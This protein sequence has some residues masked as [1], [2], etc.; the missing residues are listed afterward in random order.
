MSI[1]VKPYEISVWD[2]VWNGEKFVEKC[3]VI[4]GTNEMQSQ[5]KAIEPILTRNVN[6][7]KKFSFKMYKRYIDSNTGEEV[8]NPFMNYLISERKVK[9]HY[10]NKW[11][12]FIIKNINETS[13]SYLYSFDLEDALVVELSKNGFNVILDQQLNNNMN[14]ANELAKTVLADTDWVL[15]ENPE[16]FVQTIEDNLVYLTID[17]SKF[18][19]KIYHLIDQKRDNLTDG[20][21]AELAK[22]GNTGEIKVLGFYSS[23]RNKPYRFQFIYLNN[24]E[25]SNVQINSNRIILNQDCQYYFDVPN[26]D[27]YKGP[28]I[29]YGFYLPE[30]V[31]LLL[32]GG[33]SV[34]D[35][36]DTT[37]SYWYRGARYGFAQKAVYRS[38]LN[39]YVNIYDKEGTEY[40]GFLDTQYNSPN[41]LTNVVTNT[42]FK[43]TSGWTGA[44]IIDGGKKAQVENVFGNYNN[45]SFTDAMDLLKEGDFDIENLDNNTNKAYM[46]LTFDEDNQIVINSGPYDNRTLIGNLNEKEEWAICCKYCGPK[47]KDADGND[48]TGKLSFKIAEWYYSSIEQK[49]SEREYTNDQNQKYKKIEFSDPE[50]RN[51]YQIFT[52]QT[53]TYS[54]KE[55]KKKN[56]LRI[57]ITADTL[58][59]YYI[60]SLELF[61]VVY[62][63]KDKTK[64][65]IP[66]EQIDESM[67]NQLVEKKYKYFLPSALEGISD[68][69]ELTNVE[70]Y[71]APQNGTYVPVFNEGA[72]KIRSVDA[73]ESNYFNILQSIA[74]TFECWLT[75]EVTR[76]NYGAINEKKVAFKNYAGDNNY[77]AFRYGVNLKDIQRT[78][79]SKSIVTKLLV[80]QNAN[81]HAK[82]GFC[83]IQ[84]AASNPTGENYLYDFQ[85]YHNNGLLDAKTYLESIYANCG[86]ITKADEINTESL[87]GY[88]PK[89]RALNDELLKLNEQLINNSS[90]L[91]KINADYEVAKAAYDAAESGIEETENG[92]EAATGLNIRNFGKIVAFQLTN[93]Y[94][95]TE[96]SANS[97][98]K[99]S[100]FD[101][102][103]IYENSDKKVIRIDAATQNYEHCL[104][105]KSRVLNLVKGK[106]Y[107]IRIKAR[108]IGGSNKN[109]AMCDLW[110]DSLPESYFTVSKVEEDW[111]TWGGTNKQYWNFTT[112]SNT[113]VDEC[114]VRIFTNGG[115]LVN[116]QNQY[117]N[118]SFE[119]T[120]IQLI[121]DW[122]TGYDFG[123]VYSEDDFWGGLEYDKKIIDTISVQQE[124]TEKNKIK[125]TVTGYSSNGPV[126]FTAYPKIWV[127]S[128]QASQLVLNS[129]PLSVELT[130]GE[131]GKAKATGSITQTFTA[132]NTER[133]DI[134]RLIKDMTLYTIERNKK[135]AEYTRLEDEKSK[136]ESA[137]TELESN[138][139]NL[140]D[141]KAALNKLFYKN[142]YRFI[143]EGTWIDEQYVDDEKYYIDAQSVLYNS[144]YPQVA[145]AINVLSLSQLPGYELF[146][147]ELGDKT[148]VEDEQFFGT[149]LKEEII[150]AEMSNHL[151]SPSQDSIK[152]QNFKNQFQDLFQKITATVQQAQY[153]TGSYEK[154]VALAEADQEKK[155]QFLTDALTGVASAFQV[156]GQQSVVQDASGITIVDEDAPCNALKM[157]GGA[158]MLSK[159]DANGQQ[160][161]TTGLTADGISASLLTAG[162]INVGNIAIYN[163]DEPVFKWDAFGL[164]AYDAN[165]YQGVIGDVNTNK[166]VRFDKFGIYGMNN[167][168]GASWKPESEYD[169]HQNATFALTW[170]GLKVTGDSGIVARIGK[171]TDGIINITN[172]G[173]PIFTISNTGDAV[174]SGELS[175]ATGTFSGN[176][177]A[178]TR[179][180]YKWIFNTT[181]GLE[182]Y[183]KN[184]PYFKLT[185]TGA[186]LQGEVVASQGSIAGWS[187]QQQ[188]IG[189]GPNDESIYGKFFYNKIND[190]SKDL[191]NGFSSTA[192]GDGVIF[193]GAESLEKYS[194]AKLIVSQEGEVSGQSFEVPASKNNSTEKYYFS[195]GGLSAP[196]SYV[197]LYSDKAVLSPELIKYKNSVVKKQ[198]IDSYSTPTHYVAGHIRIHRIHGS[199]YPTSM[200][201][202]IIPTFTAKPDWYTADHFKDYWYSNPSGPGLNQFIYIKIHQIL[203]DKYTT[204]ATTPYGMVIS[205]GASWNNSTKLWEYTI[206]KTKANITYFDSSTISLNNSNYKNEDV[207]ISFSYTFTGE[208]QVS[209]YVKHTDVDITGIQLQGSLIP[210]KELATKNRCLG[211]GQYT[212][213]GTTT[214]DEK[215]YWWWDGYI[216]YVYSYALR[217]ESAVYDSSG[218]ITSDRLRK[219][220]IQLLSDIEKYSVLFDNLKP[221]VYKYNNGS[222]D[223]LHTGFIAQEV[224]EAMEIAEID[225]QD[226]AALTIE[227]YDKPEEEQI[228]RLRYEEFIALNTDQIQK[229][230]PRMSLAEQKLLDY[231]ARIAYLEQEVAAL[232]Q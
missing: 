212:L 183:Y 211:M 135:H 137:K 98:C 77:A 131:E 111:V 17:L 4:I 84:R 68:I 143:Q 220:S 122:Y 160:K 207:T 89:L 67:T 148:Y 206:D 15:P 76:D 45:N 165:W 113:D 168:D 35:N 216:R 167:V 57:G 196:L 62:T 72:E 184:T 222:S 117:V 112:P 147:F 142:Y 85:Y 108:L 109:N 187:L 166:F 46:K 115:V 56:D 151:D 44:S 202:Q 87:D 95:D 116:G 149:K 81:E 180:G 136:L 39:R 49:Y 154:A 182:A 88:M 41:L 215:D 158:I 105:G 190:G 121:E 170:D 186:F 130:G 1:L 48:A 29:N 82:N 129:F 100:N 23:C 119:I 123:A 209:S 14:G 63:D 21:I 47:Y 58:G 174:F 204:F 134:K 5:N 104:F 52:V 175:A 140:K 79:E 64:F 133:S 3:L 33:L 201:V 90:D 103:K 61:R 144:C 20:V 83:T 26:E 126:K 219:N 197:K 65:I 50:N 96:T 75:L 114:Y 55:F 101:S 223:R 124:G 203:W 150:I 153:S 7:V 177:S 159:Q 157:I 43:S 38:E 189:T 86:D 2:D 30:G 71:D 164:T 231:E 232:K 13:T 199:D 193:I 97:L 36:A 94:I 9:L 217:A 16:K 8:E 210:N 19:N 53:N 171:S 59:D 69:E 145:Y 156:A 18:E 172:N 179:T 176:L 107:A 92:F 120:E 224:K 91:T 132:V 208:T 161:W 22:F 205:G 80:K 141:K 42:D 173:T 106:N 118:N 70:T 74:E 155:S 181:S 51:E 163:E 128:E 127:G 66:N 198:Q 54:Q 152:V 229:L 218:Q 37:I 139:K 110:P 169:V 194:S 195:Y 32:K 11:Y 213:E 28:D 102:A 78:H 93:N 221:V 99:L 10:D 40:Y 138:I 24:Y 73:K 200:L 192:Q 226:F 60:E 125:F 228:W 31:T 191:Y 188:K 162:H 230:K 185:E 214:L 146:T 12:D 178:G 6:G 227:N 225:N 34:S 25:K 27:D